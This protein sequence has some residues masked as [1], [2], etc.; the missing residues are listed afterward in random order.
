MSEL[1]PGSREVTITINSDL[2]EALLRHGP[3]LLDEL[4]AASIRMHLRHG[5]LKDDF[6]ERA[7]ARK[8][9]LDVKAVQAYRMWR[10]TNVKCFKSRHFALKALASK[11]NIDGNVPLLQNL[12][13][14]RRKTVND[15][16]RGRRNR[17]VIQLYLDGLSD[18]QI[19]KRASIHPKTIRKIVVAETEMVAKLRL[20]RRQAGGAS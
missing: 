12:I 13:A 20:E 5:I 18:A 10:R 7:A 15:Y 16:I 4:Q 11:L 14:R 3:M 19:A 8:A 2:A 6:N 17:K 9:E 1:F